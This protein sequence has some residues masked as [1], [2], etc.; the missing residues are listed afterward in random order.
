MVKSE[1]SAV[2]CQGGGGRN[3][4]ISPTETIEI[5]FAPLQLQGSH[6]RSWVKMEGKGR[7]RK[8]REGKGREGEGKGGLVKSS[9]VESE[10]AGRLQNDP[11]VG[12]ERYLKLWG[13]Q[14]TERRTGRKGGEAEKERASSERVRV[15]EVEV[16]RRKGTSWSVTGWSGGGRVGGGGGGGGKKGEE[17]L[18]EATRT[19]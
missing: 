12:L 3:K 8:G 10:R 16:C 15:E 7:E 13:S 17:I 5:E 1:G 4:K 14:E 19:M 11:A 6:D 2:C 18:T 9:R